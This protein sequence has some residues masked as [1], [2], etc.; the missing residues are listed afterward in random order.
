ILE[1]IARLR[2]ES[3]V[4]L[5][6]VSHDLAVVSS[7]ADRVAVMYAG[8]IVEE[9]PTGAIVSAP[10]HPYSAGLISSVPDHVEPRRLVGIP[11][12]AVE[13]GS[14][15]ALVGESGSGKTTIARCIVGLHAPTEGRILLDGRPLALRAGARSR[16]ERR[17]IQIVFQNP[18]DSLNPRRSVEDAIA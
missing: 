17:A 2:R 5:V 4:A 12:F 18:Y 9:G 7:I 15:V 13:A 6:Y 1:E 3:D 11:G 8:R 10:R 14:C 16:E